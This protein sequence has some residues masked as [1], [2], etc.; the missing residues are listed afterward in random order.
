MRANGIELPAEL[1]LL[2]REGRALAVD[3]RDGSGVFAQQA[4]SVTGVMLPPAASARLADMAHRMTAGAG[5]VLADIPLA[6]A[7]APLV[8]VA[9]RMLANTEGERVVVVIPLREFSTQDAVAP[10]PGAAMP[11][12][13]RDEGQRPKANI[14]PDVHSGMSAIAQAMD[15]AMN[16]PIEVTDSKPV[17]S[18]LPMQ[19]AP[20]P[21][22]HNGSVHQDAPVRIVWQSDADGKITQA[23]SRLKAL[24]GDYS[25]AIV[26][27]RWA[28]LADD[29]F[30][31]TTGALQAALEGRTTANK[32]P[33]LWSA[34]DLP[35]PVDVEWSALPV[36]D[37]A[38]AF[39]GL[40]GFL[41][42]H[43]PGSAR[44][45]LNEKASHVSPVA[46]PNG[47]TQMPAAPAS[48]PLPTLSPSERMAFRELARAL[49]A[50]QE[51]E[52]AQAHHEPP[53]L[54]TPAVAGAEPAQGERQPEVITPQTMAAIADH[55]PALAPADSETAHSASPVINAVEEAAADASMVQPEALPSAPESP[56]S[57]EDKTSAEEECA[58]APSYGGE[59]QAPVMIPAPVTHIVRVPDPRYL[60]IIER[61]P[62]GVLINRSERVLF[63]NRTLLDL[64]DYNAIAD[65]NDAGGTPALFK[66]RIPVSEANGPSGAILLAA[67]DGE[68]IGVDARMQNIHWDGE[69]ATLVSFRRSAD[70]EIN[71]KLRSAEHELKQREVQLREVRAILDTATDGVAVLDEN[72]RILS[73]N[74]TAEALFGYDQKEMAGE[75]VTELMAPESRASVLDY[76]EGLKSGGVR[77]VLNDGREVTGRVRQGGRLPV[78]LS[79]GQIAEKPEKKFCA[80][81]RDLTA[82]KKSERELVDARKAAE[83]ASAQKT[84]FL[85]KISHEVRTPLNA[86]IGFAEV[87][88]EERFGAIG[89][90]R[91]KDYLKDIHASGGHVISLVNDLLDLSK[92]EAGKMELDFT[93]VNVNDVVRGAVSI[94]QPQSQRGRI[95]IRSAM[96]PKLPTIVADERALKQIVLNLLSNAVKFTD[97]G[98]QVIVSTTL[99]DLGEIAIRV[100]DTGI[101][102]TPKEV[103]QAMEPFKQLSAT[104]RAGGTGLGLPLTKA[105]VDA[106]RAAMRISSVK[107]E[108]TLVEIVFP[109]TR[110]MANH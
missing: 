34:D 33:L 41:L 96:A 66:G 26:G 72:G 19:A 17:P 52:A 32:I 101:G 80:V 78:F 14:K 58:N 2:L 56:N 81:L 25:G 75:L 85:A 31:D 30:M 40:R 35:G 36:F 91:Y 42:V 69:P 109:P 11:L 10:P 57:G 89:N 16:A 44:A 110:V 13:A 76:F 70:T 87:M 106:N 61:L 53:A 71:Q 15:T 46:L 6:G 27:R 67:R 24:V 108:G 88:I 77:S 50:R 54:P 86:I 5:A 98:G 12:A 107:N 83:A 65:M 18:S 23:G 103:E 74:R 49:G 38:R 55:V 84:D 73:I 39:R 37:A 7:G 8:P 60:D 97:P 9:C 29:I 43:A 51:N 102:M 104:R 63:A 94:M 28:D 99:S 47:E 21:H 3:A 1:E 45:E 22:S 64:L 95:V 90:E 20:Q 92:I 105:L 100:R 4:A 93:S 48:S 82:W 79:F 62:V 68:R 59:Q